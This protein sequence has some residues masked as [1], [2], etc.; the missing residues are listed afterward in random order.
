MRDEAELPPLG[1]DDLP[2]GAR[3]GIFV[4]D[5]LERVPLETLKETPEL[6]AWCTREDV[7]ALLEGTLR[8]HGRDGAQLEPAARLAHAALT[9]PLPVVG[10]TV[11]G[12]AWAPRVVREMEF[13]F[14]FPEAAGGARRGFVKGYVDVVFEHEG[15]A[16]LIDWKT[17]RLSSWD[18][19]AVEAHVAANYG[20]QERLYALALVRALG[21]TD[22]ATYE[23]RF[24]GTL[25]VFLRGLPG[26]VR[27]RRPTFAELQ[28]WERE[29]ATELAGEEGTP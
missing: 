16:Y 8:R 21:I 28:A 29:L 4:H 23:R 24:G 10:G 6:G 20:L 19:A 27:A 11:S 9:T 12:L 2:G 26:A 18:V 3:A 25:Y 7:R 1:V 22:S 5:L 17:D 14:P 15:R 13:L